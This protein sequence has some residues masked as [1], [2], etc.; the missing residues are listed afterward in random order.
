LAGDRNDLFRETPVERANRIVSGILWSLKPDR[1]PVLPALALLWLRDAFQHP[2][3]LP[4]TGAPL[5]RDRFAGMAR[6]LSVETLLE[7]YRRGFY[8]CGHFG[9]LKWIS[10]PERCVLSIPDF[11]IG[12]DV[13]R[14]MRQGRFTVSFDTAFDTVIKA[15]ADQR[16]SFGRVTWITPKIMHAYA[17][18]HD[19]GHAHSYEVWNA[20]GEL[21]G[22]GYGVAIGGTFF[23]ESQFYRE[24]NASKVGSTVL[25]WHLDRWGFS[26]ADAKSTASAMRDM[27]FSV[28]SREAFLSELA[29][30][31]AGGRPPGRWSAEAQTA[32]IATWN[33]KQRSAVKPAAV[34]QDARRI[35]ET[36]KPSVPV[37]RGVI[38][39][40]S[41]DATIARLKSIARSPITLVISLKLGALICS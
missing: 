40:P 2:P 20:A 13:R 8:T 6:D 36:K 11:H 19:A 28:M 41:A 21:I 14:L 24:R 26:L 10:P 39:N 1:L 29:D 37:R 30:T 18:L 7:A 17:A 35:T 25:M 22:G 31:S 9:T 38:S 32:D 27:G 12:K 15:C 33:P 3:A 16:K 23:G 5:L 34:V 4:E